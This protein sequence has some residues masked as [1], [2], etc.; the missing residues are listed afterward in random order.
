MKKVKKQSKI[1]YGIEITKPWSK[2]MYTHNDKVSNLQKEQLLALLE[3]F[4]QYADFSQES[5][6]NLYELGRIICGYS[7]GS[8]YGNAEI[9]EQIEREL[10]NVQNFWLNEDVWPDV[11]A[12]DWVEPL[13]VDYIGY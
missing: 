8:G 10:E 2:E 9:I 7:F 5:E 6:D 11:L 12:K 13:E 4:G 1:E 3:N